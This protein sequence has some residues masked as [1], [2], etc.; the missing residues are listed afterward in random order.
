MTPAQLEK[1]R[2]LRDANGFSQVDLVEARIEAVPLD[3]GIADCVV[4][5]GV[6]NLC[7][8]KELAYREVFRVLKPGGRIQIADIVVQSAVPADAKEDIAL[9]TG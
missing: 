6:I 1:C 4:S 3:A 2:R 7:P 5:N 8:D 9:W